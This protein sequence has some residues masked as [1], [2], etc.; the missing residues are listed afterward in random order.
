MAVASDSFWADLEVRPTVIASD[1]F[2]ADLEV[3]P[4]ASDSFWADLEVWPTVMASGSFR[5]GRA[6]SANSDN[7]E[8]S[9]LRSSQPLR[10]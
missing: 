3:R 4:T 5:G 6:S 7:L 8:F 10:N 2:W 9:A 1:S